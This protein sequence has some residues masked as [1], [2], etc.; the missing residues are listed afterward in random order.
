MAVPIEPTP[1][2]LDRLYVSLRNWGRFGQG[3]E[4]GTLALLTPARRAH[5]ASLVRSGETLSLAHDLASAPTPEQ[6]VPGQHHMLAGG[7]A[8]D[9]GGLPGYEA[10]RD[11]VGGDIHG[12]GTTHL[13][14]LCHIFVASEMWNGDPPEMVLSTGALRNSVMTVAG[15]VAGRGV[16]L[17]VPRVRGVPYLE[18]DD[19]IG[20]DDLEAAER[21]EGLSVGEGDLLVVATGRDA[22]RQAQRGRL[23]PFAEG[24]AGLHAEALPWLHERGVSVLI[25]DGISDRMPARS[26]DRWPFPIHQIGITA[27]GLHLVDNARLDDLLVACADAGRWEFLLTL[28][29]LRIPGGTGSPVNPIAL[30]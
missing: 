27:I 1:D 2:E 9:T 13:D 20:V 22:R 17:D 11:Y 8:R 26:T 10:T 29:P 4:R 30:L 6:P 24:L 3:D 23:N 14:A 5:A 28:A 12:L 7:D 16:L 19:A 15:G 18:P 21:A 25:G